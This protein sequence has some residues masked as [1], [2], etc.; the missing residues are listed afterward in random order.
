MF[1]LAGRHYIFAAWLLLIPLFFLSSER[2]AYTGEL[3]AAAPV[4]MQ[5]RPCPG[6]QMP[7]PITGTSQSGVTFP[8]AMFNGEPLRGR[9][10]DPGSRSFWHCHGGGQ[11]IIPMEGVGRV[12]KRG[13]RMRDLHI[14]EI[15]FAGPGVEH[16]H[17]ASD[18]E[19]TR[20]IQQGLS[21]DGGTGVYWLEEVTE[22]DYMGNDI[23]IN[24]RTRFL[25]T[26]VR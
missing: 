16:W 20:V 3:G 19:G 12:Q 22:D 6:E 4:D 23:G 11:Y 9:W 18:L 5:D 25:E 14:G 7:T 13:E 17:G 2:T 8:E 15:E 24:S 26:G 1:R 21:I 10:W